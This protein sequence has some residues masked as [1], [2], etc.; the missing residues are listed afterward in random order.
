MSPFFFKKCYLE[1]NHAQ[2]P[3]KAELL[4]LGSPNDQTDWALALELYL[5]IIEDPNPHAAIQ[6]EAKWGAAEI[7]RIGNS[8]VKKNLSRAIEF[9]ADVIRSPQMSGEL[10]IQAK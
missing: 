2:N 3:E 6:A 9:Y 1:L 5:K 8:S 7:L 10:K 4:R